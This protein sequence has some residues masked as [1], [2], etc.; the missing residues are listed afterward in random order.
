MKLNKLT[1]DFINNYVIPHIDIKEVN[2]GNIKELISFIEETYEKPL[3]L[4]LASGS[5]IDY[6]FFL[7]VN[8][9]LNDLSL[10][11]RKRI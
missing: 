7:S 6:D 11:S 1:N 4:E 3:S 10:N 5:E 9:V 8:D 2:E